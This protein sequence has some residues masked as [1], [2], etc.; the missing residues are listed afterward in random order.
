VRAPH[1]WSTTGAACRRSCP[2]YRDRRRE[3]RVELL[4]PFVESKQLV[5][6]F[7]EEILP[8][9]V[10]AE[11]LQHEATEI[12]QALLAHPQKRAMLLA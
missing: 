2:A 3:Q 5:A 6:A 7:D 8:E 12:A 1:E 10:A 4:Q 11:H 9:L